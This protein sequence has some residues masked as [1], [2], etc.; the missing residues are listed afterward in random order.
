M[1]LTFSLAQTLWS[2]N[3]IFEVS[4]LKKT[5]IL[6]ASCCLVY[7]LTHM[8]N[9]TSNTIYY[10]TATKADGFALYFL[11]ECNN[12]LC[13]F[14]PAGAKEGLPRLILSGPIALGTTIAAHVA[15]TRKTL[16]VE[17]ILG[18]E[19]FPKGTGLD[20]GTRI[21]SVLCLPILTAIGDLI[22]ILELYR[23]WGKD[24]FNLSHQEL[25]PC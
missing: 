7:C 9:Q 24:P 19:R 10:L 8:R 22:G 13:L 25:E 16:L 23:N 14:T 17:D 5:T 11:G 21:Q 15:K 18:D 4:D 2:H 12:S 20:S 1:S 6:F 3:N